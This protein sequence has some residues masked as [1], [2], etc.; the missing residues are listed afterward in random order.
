MV[1]VQETLCLLVNYYAERLSDVVDGIMLFINEGTYNRLPAYNMGTGIGNKV[2]EVAQAFGWLGEITD[3][4]D[5]EAIDNTADN[6]EMLKLG[7]R[8]DVDVIEYVEFMKLG[9]KGL[10]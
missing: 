2:F 10:W 1:K 7:W 6:S 5:C 9:K 8:P 4:D 3:G